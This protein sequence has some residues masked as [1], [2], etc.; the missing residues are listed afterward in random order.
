MSIF[1]EIRQ[2]ARLVAEKAQHI[3]IHHDKLDAYIA[4]LPLEKV[5]NPPLDPAVHYVGREWDTVAFFL[6]LETI[7]FG[8][9]YFPH[10]ETHGHESGYF[11]VAAALRAHYQQ[12]G[13]MT[14]R[15]LRQLSGRDCASIFQQSWENEPIREL[16]ELFAEALNQLGQFL[17]EKFEGKVEAFWEACDHSAAKLVA[18][19]TQ[20]PC[21]NDRASYGDLSIPFFK[22][23]QI[24]VADTSLA[25]S[26]KGLGYFHDLDQLT[27]FADNMVPHVLRCDGILEYKEDLA[28]IVDKS[29]LVEAGSEG[30]I[31]IR[32]CAIHVVELIKQ[33]LA[34]QGIHL[35]S[36]DLDY[37]IWNRGLDSFYEKAFPIHLTRTT[38][39]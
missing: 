25:F 15:E 5:D 7:N 22:R 4:A 19:L 30:E 37:L 17:E 29:I 10:L 14:A 31:E 12:H 9:G 24:C 33:K 39:Y 18:L 3:R 32:A 36:M 34:Q 11:T 27:I 38:F 26:N 35:R 1:D 13:P 2:Q 23:A 16:M 21:F 8:S 20:I 28:A 6:T